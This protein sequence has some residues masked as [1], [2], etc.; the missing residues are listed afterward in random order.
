MGLHR[1]RPLSVIAVALATAA[2]LTGCDTKG[3]DTTPGTSAGTSASASPGSSGGT[4]AS[5]AAS[6]TTTQ[7][8]RTKK[9]IDLEVGDCLADVP[10]ADPAVVDV[11]VVDCSQP[12]MAETFLR[13]PIPVDAALDGTAN[14]QCE[15]G[16]VQYTGR[17]S[18]GSPYL[19]GYLIDS[20]QDRTYNNP[21]PSTVICLLQGAQ[22]QSLTGSARA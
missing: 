19:I 17:A 2:P 13:A 15:T 1:L 4:G 9:W 11:T 18:V 3:A 20:H 7:A 8:P 16:F 10:P 12:H 21:L 6:P 14:P 22:G 5:A